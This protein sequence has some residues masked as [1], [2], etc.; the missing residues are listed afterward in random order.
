MLN[1]DFQ[2]WVPA[3][4]DEDDDLTFETVD[5]L[6]AFVDGWDRC[7][8]EIRGIFPGQTI[9]NPETRFGALYVHNPMS[10]HGLRV[11]QVE[12]EICVFS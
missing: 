6:K 4:V 5:E 11:L 9:T 8:E 7:R 1:W 12:H 2:D 3:D 10:F